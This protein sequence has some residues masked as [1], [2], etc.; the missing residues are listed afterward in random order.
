MILFDRLLSR[1][2]F[3][4]LLLFVMSLLGLMIQPVVAQRSGEIDRS[5]HYG[6]GQAFNYALG[7]GANDDVNAIAIQPDGK[8]II[9]GNFTQYN[10][11][12]APYLVRLHPDGSID[13][14]FRVGAA[15]NSFVHTVVLQPDGKILVGG[16]FTNFGGVSGLNY[17]VRLMP[18]G[19]IDAGF[20]QGA[21]P[22]AWVNAIAL[23]ANGKIWLGGNFS[24]YNTRDR[25]RIVL[26]EANG[27]ED[28]AFAPGTAV[29]GDFSSVSTIAIQADGK[30]LL[31]GVFESYNRTNALRIVRINPNGSI[32]GSF[33]TRN[34]PNNE[35]KSIIPLPNGKIIIGGRFL[36]VGLYS[37]Q[38]IARLNADG[39]LDTTYLATINSLLPLANDMH[40]L[41]DGSLLYAGRMLTTSFGTRSSV[42][43]I[44]PQGRVD[45][46][47]ASFEGANDWTNVIA[48]QPDGKIVLG[49]L[50]TQFNR[51]GRDH[52]VR[53]N[54]NGSL[55][56]SFNK[57][58]GADGT[59][60]KISP[61]AGGKMLISGAFTNYSG[62]SCGG[63]ARL[64]FDGSLDTSFLVNRGAN[65]IV[66]DHIILPNG[67]ILIA[68]DFTRVNGRYTAQVA[69]LLPSGEVDTGFVGLDTLRGAVYS[70]ATKSDG[71]VAFGGDFFFGQGQVNL[72]FLDSSGRVIPRQFGFGA[73]NEIYT[74][75]YLPNGKLLVGGSFTNF[76]SNTVYSF[77][78][79]TTDLQIDRSFVMGTGLRGGSVYAI[80]PLPDGKI[81]LGGDFD[82]YAGRF[83][84]GIVRLT[85]S[86]A[87]DANFVMGMGAN[88]L[89]TSL[90]LE[91]NGS[92]LIGG[93]FTTY[94]GFTAPRLARVTSSGG[95]DNSFR[96]LIGPSQAIWEIALQDTNKVLIG[97]DFTAYDNLLTYRITRVWQ[98][99]PTFS[100]NPVSTTPQVKLYPNPSRG[101]LVIESPGLGEA[102]FVNAVGQI[103]LSVPLESQSQTIQ[104]QLARGMYWV[105]IKSLSQVVAQPLIVE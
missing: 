10:S 84:P 82:A 64:N 61:L 33:D 36:R 79:L 95:F 35:V 39:S 7:I 9:G 94:N 77:M 3:A 15:A 89:V 43:K 49:G 28:N 6:Y 58:N 63:I 5:F 52:I 88:G 29:E 21:G 20:N 60:Y 91:P 103:V 46:I 1:Y 31:G 47:F 53:L 90:A 99:G 105:N 87:I 34:G 22:N 81:L 104:H 27:Q 48:V 17:L 78:Q 83:C 45:S 57:T 37:K 56:M 25:R 101:T 80:L 68:G 41:P 38:G 12:A 100:P 72:G 14:G 55:D 102:Q 76:N 40:L 59:V 54:P 19:S 16:R 30:V 71:S 92:I 74:L 42:F 97:G 73:N 11:V 23:A 50:F 32:D 26:L 66:Y 85:A 98:N 70:I 8:I 2:S 18:D 93:A 44:T 86:G 69:R 65:G 51:V 13:N 24:S 4:S 75:A 96:P 67:K 62:S